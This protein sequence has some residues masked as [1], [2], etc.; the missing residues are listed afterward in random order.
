MATI[1][2]RSTLS[3]DLLLD[4]ALRACQRGLAKYCSRKLVPPYFRPDELGDF[5]FAV[6]GHRLNFRGSDPDRLF[7]RMDEDSLLMFIDKA[8][9]RMADFF[10]E[11]TH[12]E[13][14]FVKSLLVQ[15]RY[16]RG[17]YAHRQEIPIDDQ[18]YFLAGLIR[19]LRMVEAHEEAV[20]VEGIRMRA[21][22]ASH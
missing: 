4:E 15:T 17:L 9:W 5:V 22:S 10:S 20:E 11:L 18:E 1:R 14:G 3:S 6:V 2:N 21:R 8:D 12:Y 7:E 19:L 16:F 13:R